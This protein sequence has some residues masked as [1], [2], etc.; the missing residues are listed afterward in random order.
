M[1]HISD[2]EQRELRLDSYVMHIRQTICTRCGCGERWS[3]LNE[4][5]V[6][7]TK[8][9]TTGFSQQRPAAGP[10]KPLQINTVE[11]PDRQIPICSDCIHTYQAPTPTPT[12]SAAE[13]RE[14]LKRK[15]APQPTAAVHVARATKP[16]RGEVIDFPA[17][18]PDQL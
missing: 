10:L 8:T 9:R 14:T 6:H 13:W 7:P 18:T 2:T 15:Y 4:V 12:A 1:H 16:A 11:H 3:E 5:W 17:P